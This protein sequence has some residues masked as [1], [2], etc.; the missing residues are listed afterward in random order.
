MSDRSRSTGQDR[1]MDIPCISITTSV[2]LY[3]VGQFNFEL[4]GVI[5]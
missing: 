4:S 1:K 2:C 5:Y 3:V